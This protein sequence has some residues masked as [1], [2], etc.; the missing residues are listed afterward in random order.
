MFRYVSLYLKETSMKTSKKLYDVVAVLQVS[1]NLGICLVFWGG[2]FETEN[3][4][5]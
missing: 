5:I 1:Q 3:N 4:D 2:I